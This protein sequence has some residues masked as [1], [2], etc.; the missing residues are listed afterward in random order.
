[1]SLRIA[2]EAAVTGLK[3]AG[4]GSLIC[5]AGSVLYNERIS[6]YWSLTAQKKPY[7]ILHPKFTEDVVKIVK[8]V[9]AIPDLMFAVRS[10][11]HIAWVRGCD[12]QIGS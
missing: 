2:A 7:A 12:E 8:T 10:G 3:E 5:A 1:M 6:S 11:G 4:L 9:V